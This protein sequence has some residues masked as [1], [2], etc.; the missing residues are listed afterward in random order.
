MAQINSDGKVAY[1]YNQSS[2]FLEKIKLDMQKFLKSIEQ[3][4]SL[5][6]ALE[7]V[8]DKAKDKSKTNIAS[9]KRI[10][11]GRYI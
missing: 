1:V 10:Y 5:K 9:S 11:F 7:E 8:K 2:P 3:K 4:N 6:E